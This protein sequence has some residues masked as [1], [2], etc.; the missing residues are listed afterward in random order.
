M[1]ILAGLVLGSNAYAI[2]DAGLSYD[3]KLQ[4]M[5]QLYGNG[6]TVERMDVYVRELAANSGIGEDEVASYLLSE[7]RAGRSGMPDEQPQTRS[8][9]G[10]SSHL[11]R[12]DRKGDFFYMDAWAGPINH[13]HTGIYSSRDTIVEAPGPGKTVRDMPAQSRGASV[14]TYLR[15]VKTSQDKRNRAADH[16]WGYRGRGYNSAFLN[17]NK[18]DWGGMHCA[19]LVWAAYWYG[20]GID[21][22]TGN[23]AIVWPRDLRS[24]N[25][26]DTYKQVR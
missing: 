11:P 5:V 20:A 22:D 3:H 24:T 9:G 15:V 1:V 2:A 12:A 18:N 17:G 23:D 14:H 10:G 6:I 16:A 21:L 7:W 25:K 8:G 19:Q 13:G 4:Q 26:A